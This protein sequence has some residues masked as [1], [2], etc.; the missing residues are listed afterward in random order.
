MNTYISNK[1]K[2]SFLSIQTLLEA[3]AEDIDEM[4]SETCDP[5]TLV[6]YISVMKR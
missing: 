3:S 6:T 1:I 5:N 2:T 4:I